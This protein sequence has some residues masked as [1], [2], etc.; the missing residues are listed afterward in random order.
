MIETIR[1]MHIPSAR[2]EAAIAKADEYF[3]ENAT[4][5]EFA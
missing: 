4:A 3:R 1:R 2:E 5:D